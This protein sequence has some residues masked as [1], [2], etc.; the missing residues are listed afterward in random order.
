M[1]RK[2][3]PILLAT[4]L[5]LGYT[6]TF[7]QKM[8]VN[9]ELDTEKDGKMLVGYQLKDQLQKEPYAQWYNQEYKEY[10]TDK[11]AISDLKKQKLNSYKIHAVLGTW[12]EYSHRE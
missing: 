11:K 10:Q 7:A 1:K 5:A 8:V 2:L 4:V 9:R 12:C 3:K 6:T